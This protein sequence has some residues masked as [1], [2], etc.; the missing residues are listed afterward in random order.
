MRLYRSLL[1]LIAIGA[2]AQAPRGAPAP[3][4]DVVITGGRLVDGT[5]NPWVY[6]DVGIQGDR[7]ATIAPGGALASAPTAQRI[8]A[9]GRVVAPGFIDIQAQ[10]YDA[11]LFGD[12]RVISKIA[13]GVTTEILG[14]G[15]TPA[16]VNQAMVDALAPAESV[17]KAMS[18]RFI[19]THGFGAWLDA[20]ERHGGVDRRRGRV[21]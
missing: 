10:S 11:H 15:G 9:S 21:G 13:Q 4:Y 6:G 16:P 14:E 19:G 12:G 5:G 8:D 2:C 1:V 17:T 3:S 18:R 7:I 20:M